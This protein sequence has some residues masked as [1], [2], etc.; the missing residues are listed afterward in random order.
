MMGQYWK[1]LKSFGGH[2]CKVQVMRHRGRTLHLRWWDPEK[3]GS[4]SKP[5]K[6]QA[7]DSS[8]A[9]VDAAREAAFQEA[10]TLSGALLAGT[11]A[12]AAGILTLGALFDRYEERRTKHKKG[13]QPAEDRRRMLIWETVL[14]SDRD[15]QTIGPADMDDFVRDRAAGTIVLPARTKK[16]PGLQRN[17][18][19]G[20]IGADIVFLNTVFNWAHRVRL[21]DGKRLLLENPI[22]DYKRP[23][24]KNP[25]QAVATYDRFL[26]VRAHA[27]AVDP[28]GLFQAF[29]DLVEDLGWRVSA[30]R[31]LKREDIDGRKT[32]T[33]PWGRI[34]KRGEFDKEGRDMWIPLSSDAR[35]VLDRIPVL[36]GWL[37]PS[38]KD[39]ARAWGRFHARN[40]LKRAEEAA[41][42][43]ALDGAAFHAYRRK[44]ATERKHL[45][46][47]DVAFAGGWKDLRTLERAYQQVDPHTLLSVVTEKRKL[48]EAK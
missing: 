25:R 8:A 4:V 29:M 23:K 15:V 30:I 40:L 46:T 43:D 10:K 32:K 33:E 42:L 12:D 2:G 48:R 16:K 5:A 45:P 47:K 11:K 34:K 39:Q 44:W 14:G 35:R 19:D 21:A 41:G 20:T 22:D 31:Q 7:T 3:K 9:A 1:Q 38:P 18:S 36:S 27:N 26:K 13:S 6:L 28:Q 37:F 24:A 17:V